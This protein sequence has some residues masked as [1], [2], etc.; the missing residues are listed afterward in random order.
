MQKQYAHEKKG[1]KDT[2]EKMQPKRNDYKNHESSMMWQKHT[3]YTLLTLL[4]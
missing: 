1:E 2:E 4:F 3:S